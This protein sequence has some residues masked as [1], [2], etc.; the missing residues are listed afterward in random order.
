MGSH[1]SFAATNLFRAPTSP[2]IFTYSGTPGDAA[3][4]LYFVGRNYGTASWANPHP[5]YVT[6]QRTDNGAG[7]VTD[8]T[9]RAAQDTYA[10]NN[11]ND[12]ISVDFGSGKT[13]VVT[14]Y[15]AQIRNVSDPRALRNW[16]IQGSN[17]AASNSV[18]DLNAATWAEIDI[19]V[20]N[21][22]M[23]N[24]ASA[25]VH[26]AASEGNVNAYRWIR[27]LQNGLNGGSV[28][29]NFL[30]VCEWEFYGTLNF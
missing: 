11:A 16:K 21:T 30:A 22:D 13:A 1:Q 9:D 19:K 20:A 5:T 14:D 29:D 2:Q 10:G 27:L 15:T 4:M 12:F 24:T 28:P 8:L 25:H 6:N 18:S 7:T 3:G 23:A 17:D 26:Y